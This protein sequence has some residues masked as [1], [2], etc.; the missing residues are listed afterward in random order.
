[1]ADAL[2][3]LVPQNREIRHTAIWQNTF[4]SHDPLLRILVK[5]EKM[6]NPKALQRRDVCLFTMGKAMVWEQLSTTQTNSTQSNYRY[7]ISNHDKS[8]PSNR[9]ELY[10]MQ[11]NREAVN[12]RNC[13][14][15]FRDAA[16]DIPLCLNSRRSFS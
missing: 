13:Q 11:A 16:T 5:S 9:I 3:L 1:M 6:G 14:S 12:H 4:Q 15:H 7:S 8:I 2:A 10:P